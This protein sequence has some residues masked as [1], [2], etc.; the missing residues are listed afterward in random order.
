ME[1]GGNDD[2]EGFSLASLL[3]QEVLQ[4]H[5]DLPFLHARFHQSQQELEG[6]V[7][8]LTG[9]ADQF[10]FSGILHAPVFKSDLRERHAR[11]RVPFRGTRR[12]GVPHVVIHARGP[13][14]A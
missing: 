13:G 8:D 12:G 10:D 14:R 2:V 11:L 7:H 4:V 5:G 3:L 1:Q 9:G 6:P